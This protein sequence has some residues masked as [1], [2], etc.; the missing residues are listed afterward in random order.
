VDYTHKDKK[1]TIVSSKKGLNQSSMG[2]SCKRS[3]QSNSPLTDYQMP[4]FFI[5]LFFLLW[6]A[7]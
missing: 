7:G 5:F 3:A 4:D 2:K 6:Q 1:I